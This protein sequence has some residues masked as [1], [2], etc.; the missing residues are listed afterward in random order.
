L[1]ALKSSSVELTQVLPVVRLRLERTWLT[2]R[3]WTWSQFRERILEHP[4]YAWFAARLVWTVSTATETRRSLTFRGDGQPVDSEDRLLPPPADNDTVALWHP[5]IPVEP[6]AVARW[7]AY[8]ERYAIVQPIKQAHRETYV[9]TPA[10]A[11]S[12]TYSNRFAGHIIRQAQANALGR[13]RGWSCRSRI[14]ADVPN[15]SP[16][17]IK[18]PAYGLAAEYW[19]EGVGGE[20]PEVTES[21][22]YVFLK[23]DRVCFR[24]LIDGGDWRRDGG[25]GL[26]L[27]AAATRL[28]DV[29][30]ILFSEVMRDVDLFVGV[31][32]IGHDPAW[33]DGGSDAQHP[34]QWR[35]DVGW[36]YWHA[37][38][39]A[40]LEESSRQ[41]RS[42][43]ANLIPSLAI[44]A[45][46]ALDERYL[47]VSGTIRTYKIHIGTGNIMMEPEG[48]YLCIVPRSIAEKPANGRVLL[49]FEGDNLLSVILSKAFMLA[50]DI[51]IT[52]RS[53]LEQI[54]GR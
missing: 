9:L 31:A 49:P 28:V 47:I 25:R 41:R 20:A 50:N 10:E 53:I 21:Q 16:T 38:N 54:R 46:L 17:H 23:T 24:Q 51:T 35:R 27:G 12:G 48:R 19:T 13:S 11:E 4:V 3:T 34:N 18:L 22:A 29:P 40:E 5:I 36:T 2:G 6:D 7:R 15:D 45:K 1:K 8:F 14:W 30:P 43:I 33:L 42:F 26:V 37:F 44:A 52:D 39:A 32:S